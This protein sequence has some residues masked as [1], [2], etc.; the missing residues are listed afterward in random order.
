MAEEYRRS[1]LGTTGSNLEYSNIEEGVRSSRRMQDRLS[2]LSQ[3]AF[4]DL[5]EQATRQ[6]QEYA[7]KNRPSLKQI[8]DAVRKGEDVKALFA[9]PGTVFGDNARVMQAELFRQDVSQNLNNRIADVINAVDRGMYEGDANEFADS[10]QAEIDGIYNVLADIDPQAGLK[11]KAHGVTLSNTVYEKILGK[12]T[13]QFIAEKEAT[14]ETQKQAYATLLS[15]NLVKTNGNF[16]QAVA[17]TMSVKQDLFDAYDALPSGMIDAHYNDI[18]VLEQEVFKQ[19]TMSIIQNSPQL[20]NNFDG[21]YSNLIVNNPPAE[22]DFYR[23]LPEQTK[24]EI[25]ESVQALNAQEYDIATKQYTLKERNAKQ[26]LAA[27][28]NEFTKLENTTDV[29]DPDRQEKLKA[30]DAQIERLSQI[31]PDSVS[32]SEWNSY[33]N[34]EYQEIN[35]FDDDALE[36]RKK[37]QRQEFADYAALEEYVL[38]NYPTKFSTPNEVSAT[39]GKLFIKENETY[40]SNVAHDVVVEVAPAY[41]TSTDLKNMKERLSVRIRN[42]IAE[43]EAF[44]AT[45]EDPSQMKSTDAKVIANELKQLTEIIKMKNND[46]N[47]FMSGMQAILDDNKVR[48]ITV[49]ENLDLN[50]E[51]TRK[52]LQKKLGK[53]GYEQFANEYQKMK[54]MMTEIKNLGEGIF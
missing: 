52:T 6:G 23:Y 17:L 9:Q 45:V 41:Y 22:L 33:K 48:L 38:K 24:M 39:F 54:N 42:T 40:L 26:S 19:S 29:Q 5:T 3:F 1:L 28:K 30:L 51:S 49:D 34:K 35:E 43:N 13:E 46:L 7:V 12:Q 25:V 36:I 37:I 10:I 31:H 4:R 44:N 32:L 20:R 27:L 53:K 8:G 14:V 47:N 11:F 18:M 21:V 2:Q 15:A 16:A 50:H